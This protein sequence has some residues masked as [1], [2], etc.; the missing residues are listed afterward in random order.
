MRYRVDHRATRPER[1]RAYAYKLMSRSVEP[2][3]CPICESRGV[4][5]IAYGLPSREMIESAKKGEIVLGGC[6]VSG[7]DPQWRCTACRHEWPGRADARS[8]RKSANERWP[9]APPA[10]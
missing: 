4:V 3:E 1:T 9:S 2:S 10:G 7:N 8:A 6:V 5:R